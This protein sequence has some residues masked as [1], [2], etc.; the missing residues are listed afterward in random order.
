[1]P[2]FPADYDYDYDYDYTFGGVTVHPVGLPWPR[3]TEER[4]PR[5]KAEKFPRRYWDA[6][7]FALVV[8]AEFAEKNWKT[9]VD[10]GPH[11]PQNVEAELNSLAAFDHEDRSKMLDEIIKQSNNLASYWLGLLMF[12][13]RSHPATFDL[14]NVALRVGQFAVMYFK[15]KYNR[16][17]PSQFDPRIFPWID[18]PGHP[19]Y[20][21]GHATEAHLLS[22]CLAEVVPDA[23]LPLTR[24]AE[25]VAENRELAGVH[26][27]SDSDA[28]KK[29]AEGCLAVLKT[30]TLFNGI[31]EQAKA[32]WTTAQS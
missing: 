27:R 11:D 21:S 30:C 8:L 28:G 6:H 20:P 24:L 15:H 23:K 22:L 19:S 31:L 9:S 5:L 16:P 14:I 3:D 26:Y 2:I 7:R 25:R 32:E 4:F 29:L 10:P 1:M 17:R 18:V 13:S 12:N